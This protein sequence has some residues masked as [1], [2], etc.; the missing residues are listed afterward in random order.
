MD[1][2][3]KHPLIV[4]A[5]GAFKSQ[6]AFA[7]AIGSSQSAVSRMLLREIPVT[8]E[9]AVAIERATKDSPHAISRWELRPDLWDAPVSDAEA[10]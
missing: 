5:L 4:K 7:R 2:P 3:Q 10:A 9:A 6:D 1:D 8:A